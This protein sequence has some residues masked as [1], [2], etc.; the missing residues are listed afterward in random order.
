M[1]KTIPI[2]C[3]GCGG[4][5][6]ITPEMEN[7]SCGY[8]GTAQIVRR[9]GGT[10]SLKIVGDAIKRVQAGTDKTAAELAIKRLS[11]EL[12][13]INYSIINNNENKRLALKENAQVFMLLSA[14]M[15]IFFFVVVVAPV[16]AF[17][18]IFGYFIVVVFSLAGTIAV[19]YFGIKKHS[20]ISGKFEETYMLLSAAKQRLETKIADNRKLVD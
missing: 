9:S 8:C 20:Q 16:S 3:A 10:I 12:N 6:D 5:L 4:N 15:A 17:S 2:K 7:F 14:C 18:N 13:L 19:I 11:G 1:L